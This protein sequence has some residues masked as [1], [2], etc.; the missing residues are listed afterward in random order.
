MIRM[1]EELKERR[2]ELHQQMKEIDQEI[3][4]IDQKLGL[5]II[6]TDRKLDLVIARLVTDRIKAE[7]FDYRDNLSNPVEDPS[8]VKWP[9]VTTGPVQIW[10]KSRMKDFKDIPGFDHEVAEIHSHTLE[11]LEFYRE[12]WDAE[13]EQDQKKHMPR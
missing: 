7:Y 8:D 6:P 13:Y 9:D 4:T 11:N 1:T 5:A 12:Q 3:R 2:K 10:I